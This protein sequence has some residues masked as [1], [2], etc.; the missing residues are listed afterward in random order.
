M[1]EDQSRDV[2]VQNLKDA[3]CDA[4]TIEKFMSDLQTG[5]EESGLKQLAIHR[6][7]LLTAF[8]ISAIR[9]GTITG[10]K[11]KTLK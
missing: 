3:G 11:L 1:C 10:L 2:I 5:K 7:K 8:S 4:D 6:K 9:S